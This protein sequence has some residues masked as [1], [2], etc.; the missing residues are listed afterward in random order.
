MTIQFSNKNKHN[1]GVISKQILFNDYTNNELVH[2]YINSK[3]RNKWDNKY[4][5][6][7]KYCY[8][9][10]SRPSSC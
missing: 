1:G 5:R 4:P 3:N 9:R 2:L 6:K 10:M 8:D 7:I